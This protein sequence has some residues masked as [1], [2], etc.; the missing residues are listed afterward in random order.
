[1]GAMAVSCSQDPQVLGEVEPQEETREPITFNVT[2]EGVT[3]GEIMSTS[4]FDSFMM[5]AVDS[6]G[7]KVID[8]ALFTKGTDGSFST[9]TTFYWTGFDVT[10][11]AYATNVDG[12]SGVTFNDDYT[13]SYTMPEN[14]EK[15]PDLFVAVT[16]VNGGSVSIKFTRAL[17]VI[18][19]SAKGA[20][21][22]NIADVAISNFA[23]SGTYDF[24]S[25]ELGS[26]DTKS[27]TAG[28]DTTVEPTSS[29]AVITNST[30]YMMV[31]PQTVDDL[32]I[33]AEDAEGYD[34]E[35]VLNATWANGYKYNYTVDS[36][37]ISSSYTMDFDI[38]EDDIDLTLNDGD[39]VTL[40]VGV[41]GAM[42]ESS[43][44]DVAIV[45]DEG[46]ITAVGEG[47]ATITI[48]FTVNGVEVT[49][50]I[51][52]VVTGGS[53]SEGGSEEPEDEGKFDYGELYVGNYIC[54]DGTI[55]LNEASNAIGYIFYINEA[56]GYALAIDLDGV[57]KCSY[58]CNSTSASGDYNDD[59]DCGYYNTYE[60]KGYSSAC[61]GCWNKGEVEALMDPNDET[62]GQ[63]YLPAKY[64]LDT[65]GEYGDS[66][67]VSGSTYY[68]MYNMYQEVNSNFGSIT[69]LWSS[70]EVS[71][72][73]VYGLSITSETSSS[74]SKTP[75][76]GTA[77][78]S[79]IIRF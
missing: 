14:V 40:S 57:T 64:E 47:T 13:L 36:E 25:W 27:Y 12:D 52:I 16:T 39:S 26:V 2:T 9:A 38:D 69:T 50:K 74:S 73:N 65:I 78:Y 62:K 23:T 5:Y 21:G 41:D 32:T 67:Y 51:V 11:Y 75:T 48:T 28:I 68:G 45:D 18:Q 72:T 29:G 53:G 24:A 35:Y 61:L 31:I 43:N 58:W 70:T 3:R 8:G 60:A 56:E 1:M 19:F 30:G 77:G 76:S 54:S 46:N 4:T 63:W 37:A 79:A 59:Y 7:T 49:L 42:W 44:E 17:S 66:H 22:Y 10:F 55:T 33:V 20:D 34:R 71:S 15:Q 6:Q